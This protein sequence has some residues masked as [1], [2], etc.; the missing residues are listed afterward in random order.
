M[1]I[2]Q[3]VNIRKRLAEHKCLLK[4]NNHFN[5]KLQNAWSKHSEDSF[6]F[7]VIEVCN[8]QLLND[9]EIEYIH[10]FDSIKNGYN[11][12][13]GG[14]SCWVTEESTKELLRLSKKSKPIYQI[15][16]NGNIINT[17][18]G[19]KEA[20]KKL[21]LNH[22]NIQKCVRKE[23]KSYKNFVWVY[24]DEYES[25]SINNHFAK[26]E[27]KRRAAIPVARYSL[28]M[29]HL[30]SYGSAIEAM[31]DG[32]DPSSVYKCC[33]GLFGANRNKYKGFIWQYA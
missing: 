10:V 23:I 11:L 27:R 20:S 14:D 2:G 9:L 33:K 1:Y 19:I 8:E 6:S 31:Q 32:F 13:N 4:S 16:F 12:K 25:F 18:Y 26:K 24:V 3:S 28:E 7:Y 15:D 21:N 17:W 29:E 30:Q 22:S 5:R